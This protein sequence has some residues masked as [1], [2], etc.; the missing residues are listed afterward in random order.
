MHL[1]PFRALLMDLI[2]ISFEKP[3][4]RYVCYHISRAL[5]MHKIIKFSDWQ[6]YNHKYPKCLMHVIPWSKCNQ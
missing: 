4:R 1:F 2:L 6:N 5:H 3:I